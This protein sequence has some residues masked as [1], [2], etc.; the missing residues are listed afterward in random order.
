MRSA[1]PPATTLRIDHVPRRLACGLDALNCT[2]R[3]L[4]WRL[5]ALPLLGVK[6]TLT[7]V[8]FFGTRFQL[9]TP[10]GRRRAR[11]TS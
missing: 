3:L 5:R 4:A 11:M 1:T 2:A 9:A 6:T 10:C 7:L 8:F